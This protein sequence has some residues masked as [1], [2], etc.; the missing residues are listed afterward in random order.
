M[1]NITQKILTSVAA[2]TV[3]AAP[4]N[5]GLREDYHQAETDKSERQHLCHVIKEK[6]TFTTKR[7][8]DYYNTIKPLGTSG[9]FIDQKNHV[10]Y[11]SGEIG[12]DQ[13]GFSWQGT[14]GQRVTIENA[15][16]EAQREWHYE[17]G[18]LVSYSLNKG[19]KKPARNVYVPFDYAGKNTNQEIIH[20]ECEKL[21]SNTGES[22]TYSYCVS[23]RW[24][25]SYR[26]R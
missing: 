13:C 17:N 9:L 8:Q 22:F 16:G 6:I 24:D 14:I 11:V 19:S 4:V 5:A 20:R 2:L 12:K 23:Q 25:R 10:W 26:V 3:I 1:K 18:N 15:L 7:A 21:T